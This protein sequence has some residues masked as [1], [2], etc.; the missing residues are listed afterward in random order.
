MGYIYFDN[1]AT[2][3][4]LDNFLDNKLYSNP[5][6]VHEFGINAMEA[7]VSVKKYLAEKIGCSHEE[8]YFTSGATE[9][10]NIAVLGSNNKSII[11]TKNQHPS[12]AGPIKALHQKKSTVKYLDVLGGFLNIRELEYAIDQ[13][14]TLIS[15]THVNN[16]SGITEDIKKLGFLIKKNNPRALFHVDGAQS[17]GK[18]EINL[19]ACN[20]DLFTF[21]AHKIHGNK[22]FGGLVINKG[23]NIKPLFYGGQQQNGIR[24]GTEDAMAALA[25][26][27]ACSAAFDNIQKNYQHAATLRDTMAALLSEIPDCVINTDL[28]NSSPYILNASFLGIKGEILLNAL[29]EK[30]VYVATGAACSGRQVSN[31]LIAHNFPEGHAE[32]AIRFSFSRYNTVQEVELC[33]SILKGEVKKL[34][35]ES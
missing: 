10:N 13:D 5:S 16:E 2:T 15:L 21:S 33:V 18:F 14:T 17:F 30:G 34:R 28:E 7:I 29:S 9:S 25:F 23:V 24:P 1:A 27:K 26:K 32:S 3:K 4:P 11:T 22:G 20:I 31:N 6:S 12:V 35:G 8:I 19:K